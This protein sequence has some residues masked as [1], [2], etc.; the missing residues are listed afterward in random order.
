[1][2]RQAAAALQ[3][4]NTTLTNEIENLETLSKDIENQYAFVETIIRYVESGF[5]SQGRRMA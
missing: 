4:S 2:L 3:A 5:E 1:M